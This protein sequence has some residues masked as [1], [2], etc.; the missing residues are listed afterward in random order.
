MR[1]FGETRAAECPYLSNP[2]GYGTICLLCTQARGASTLGGKL[3]VCVSIRAAT[4]M[5]AEDTISF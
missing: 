5:T 1:D 3:R 2:R 4:G